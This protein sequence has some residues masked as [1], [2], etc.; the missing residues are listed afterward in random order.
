MWRDDDGS[1]MATRVESLAF[2][3]SHR[4]PSKVTMI[5]LWALRVIFLEVKNREI[6]RGEQTKSTKT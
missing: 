5:Y 2:A 6:T 1:R 4:R 3:Q